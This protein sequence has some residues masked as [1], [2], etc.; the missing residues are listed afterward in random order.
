MTALI[1]LRDRTP[2]GKTHFPNER[3]ATMQLLAEVKGTAPG[4]VTGMLEDLVHSYRLDE[5][6]LR[7]ISKALVPRNNLHQSSAAPSHE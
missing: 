5:V 3:E 7:D 6:E 2:L 1:L 4:L